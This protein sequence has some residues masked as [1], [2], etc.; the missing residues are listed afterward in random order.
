MTPF[1]HPIR[2]RRGGR[3]FQGVWRMEGGEIYVDC[4]FGADHCRADGVPARLAEILL[5]RLA[6]AAAART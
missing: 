3:D 4:P 1:E 5:G 6:F 2:I